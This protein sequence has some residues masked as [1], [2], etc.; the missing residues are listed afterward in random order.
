MK[1]VAIVINSAWHG[2]N[3]RLNLARELKI[4]NYDVNFIAPNDDKYSD[5]LKEE[6]SFTNIDFQA[7]GINPIDDLRVF[8]SL[9]RVFKEI[10]PDIVLN[11]T[12]KP[13]IYSTI[14][15]K[16]LGIHSINNVTGLGTVFVR[17]TVITIIVK[18]LYKVSMMFS[19]HVFFQNSDDKRYFVNSNL[20]SVD[21]CSIIPGSGVDTKKFIPGNFQNDEIFRFLLVARVIRDKGIYEYINASK[22]LKGKYNKVE[23]GLLGEI[24]AHNRTSISKEEILKFHNAG[25]IN[26]IGKTDN[27]REQLLKTNC[28]VLP[29]YR[30]GSPRSLMEAMSMKIPVVATDVPGCRHIVDDS[31]NGFLCKVKDSS[32]LAYNMERV[33]NLTEKERIKM[34]VMGRRKMVN[35][36]DESIVIDR[37]LDKLN[38]ILNAS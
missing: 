22:I 6:F 1:K 12:I 37:Y 26:Y 23:F 5:K 29:S 10:K 35:L 33:I 28:V 11:F 18:L 8:F 21:K 2:Y 19:S 31:I 3:F 27:V 13:N 25:T 20:V 32:D 14:V 16:V 7:D 36:Y 15:A 30:E 38:K 4:N 17:K 24:G 9:F 34:G